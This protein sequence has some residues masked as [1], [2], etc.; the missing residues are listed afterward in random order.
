MNA[1]DNKFCNIFPNF[2]KSKVWYFMETVC[3]QMILMKYQALYVIFEK[4][5]SKI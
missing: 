5:S 3:Q 2:L 4:K 1:A